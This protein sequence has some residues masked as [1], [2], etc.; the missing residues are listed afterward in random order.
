MHDCCS[1]RNTDQFYFYKELKSLSQYLFS[2]DNVIFLI[3]FL[4]SAMFLV[5]STISSRS[6]S[7]TSWKVS[8][9]VDIILSLNRSSISPL[10]TK[11]SNSSR[12]TYTDAYTLRLRRK[13][14]HCYRRWLFHLIQ[15]T[16]LP[17]LFW[18]R[19][20]CQ[21]IPLKTH[22]AVSSFISIGRRP[23]NFLK[24]FH[25]LL[26]K[27]IDKIFKQ[28]LLFQPPKNHFA[29]NI[30]AICFVSTSRVFSKGGGLIYK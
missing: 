29:H 10:S 24:T 5:Y 12:K 6:S 16:A 17:I 27:H 20:R 1:F 18:I 23:Y 4:I 26:G 7:R 13:P 11:F 30:H 25:F 9:R 22:Q 14:G 8:T 15:T 21:T 2:S 28:C 3:L 19:D